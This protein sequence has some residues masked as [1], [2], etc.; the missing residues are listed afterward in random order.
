MAYWILD[1]DNN[2]GAM[3]SFYDL[4]QTFLK[5]IIRPDLFSASYMNSDPPQSLGTVFHSI[6]F[7]LLTQNLALVILVG[8]GLIFSLIR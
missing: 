1:Y 6:Y 4:T 7:E 8:L 5:P 2:P 3:K